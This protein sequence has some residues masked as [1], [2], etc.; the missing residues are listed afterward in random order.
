MDNY[1]GEIR[2]FA[3]NFA[4]EGWLFCQG[5]LLSISQNDA[6]YALL[7]TTYGGDGQT[8]FGLPDLRGRAAVGMGAG[9]GLSP[10]RQGQQAGQESVT[11]TAAQLPVHQHPVQGTMRAKAGTPAQA[12]PSQAYFGDQGGP[13]YQS[14]ASTAALAP[15]AVTGQTNPAGSSQAHANMQ[16]LLATNYI[17]ATVGIFPSQQ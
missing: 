14:G 4:P 6:L 1:I 15:D 8:T 10:Y 9:P 11:L 17:I 5:Q 3:G 2:I 16:P 12:S 13:S 7:G